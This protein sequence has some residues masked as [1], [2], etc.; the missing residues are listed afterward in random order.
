VVRAVAD[1]NYTE[2]LRS[3]RVP[4]LVLVGSEDADA[5]GRVRDHQP[6]HPGARLEIL[7]GYGHSLPREA[8]DDVVRLVTQL[9]TA[10]PKE[11]GDISTK[12]PRHQDLFAG[13]PHKVLRSWRLGVLA[14]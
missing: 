12:T 7:Q 13:I 5:A 4:A 1:H 6:L 8:P 9:D 10:L 14:S 2:E 11:D 3:V